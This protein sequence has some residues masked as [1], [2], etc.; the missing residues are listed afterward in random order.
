MRVVVRPVKPDPGKSMLCLR[1]NVAKFYVFSI[2][3]KITGPI[4][5]ARWIV[6]KSREPALCIK[7]AVNPFK[8]SFK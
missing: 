2:K 1:Y 7:F 6:E 8:L 5:K 4:C 3:F